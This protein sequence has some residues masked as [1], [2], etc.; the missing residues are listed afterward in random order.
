MT[1]AFTGGCC[2]G[3]WGHK[4]TDRSQQINATAPGLKKTVNRAWCRPRKKR[5]CR[6]S[7][8]NHPSGRGLAL[9]RWGCVSQHSTSISRHGPVEIKT[10][11]MFILYSR[12]RRRVHVSH[13]FRLLFYLNGGIIQIVWKWRDHRRR[14]L[15]SFG[16]G[17]DLFDLCF[18]FKR[19]HQHLSGV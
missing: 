11:D 17:T 6:I 16:R 4:T 7:S 19:L 2:S 9:Q 13:I 8:R 14:N 3:R 5:R 18:D 1:I 15:K 10:R 12:F